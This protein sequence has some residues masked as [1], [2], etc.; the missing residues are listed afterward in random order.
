MKNLN[1]I[2]TGIALT[3]SLG[4][5]ATAI[6][7]PWQMGGNRGQGAQAGQQQGMQYGAHKQAARGGLRDGA[8]GRGAQGAQTG[9]QLM[10]T[11]ERTAMREKMRAAAT[12][13]E[14][15]QIAVANHAE[16]QKRAQEQG[17]TLPEQRGPRNRAGTGPNA[18]VPA[19]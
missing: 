6:A 3:V 8:A 17:I 7:H 18:A 14:R 2:A 9:R 4:L 11:E 15:Q 12:P 19:N 1:K 10:T 16:M 13:E 5:A